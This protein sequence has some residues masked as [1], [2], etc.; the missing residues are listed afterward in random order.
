LDEGD[1]LGLHGFPLSPLQI[2]AD[3]LNPDDAASEPL[4]QLECL[5]AIPATHIDHQLPP[6]QAELASE[7]EQ[8]VRSA[9]IQALLEE[10]LDGFVMQLRPGVDLL[11]GDS[12]RDLF[13]GRIVPGDRW[14]QRWLDVG[15]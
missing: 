6:G 12:G 7:V 5:L 10:G 13:H 11:E 14:G 1:Q 9:W 2:R 15:L 3:R 8:H 4:R